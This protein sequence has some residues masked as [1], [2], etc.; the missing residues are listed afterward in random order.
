MIHGNAFALER[1]VFNI[2]ENA[3]AYAPPGGSVEVGVQ[4]H[5]GH[6]VL[7]VADAGIGISPLDVPHLGEPFYRGDRARSVH[8]G[9]AGL[10]LA[11]V[12][13]VMEDHRGSLQV[14]SRPGE[15]TTVFLR[16]PAA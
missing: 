9:G 10:G 16:L 15:G 5:G 4:R 11:I 8:T 12:K 1:A 13:A 14:V 6:V 7:S 2:L 3:I